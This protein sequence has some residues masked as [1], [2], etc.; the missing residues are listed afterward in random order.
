MF[1]G[2]SRCHTQG[3]C[4]NAL[5]RRRG[6][7]GSASPLAYQT[8]CP[9]LGPP[10]AARFQRAAS[11]EAHRAWAAASTPHAVAKGARE[12]I[13]H[14]GP[15][16][17]SCCSVPRSVRAYHQSGMSGP[18]FQSVGGAGREEGK[19]RRH[20]GWEP[21]DQKGGERVGTDTTATTNTHHRRLAAAAFRTD[22]RR[23]SDGGYLF[24]AGCHAPLA[25]PSPKTA[26]QQSA[27]KAPLNMSHRRQSRP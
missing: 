9:Q 18:V 1:P 4:D 21:S 5:G 27:N 2:F 23:G 15:T 7:K 11:P 12:P 19:Q 6:G 14:D 13:G 16:S 24:T 17:T 8:C 10:T 22:V 3:E 26:R 20:R 25:E